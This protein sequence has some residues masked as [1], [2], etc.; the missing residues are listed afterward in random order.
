[1]QVI[2]YNS[3]NGDN[4]YIQLKY[5]WLNRKHSILVRKLGKYINLLLSG[6]E[7]KINTYKWIPKW[8]TLYKEKEPCHNYT[9]TQFFLESDKLTPHFWIEPCGKHRNL[10]MSLGWLYSK[11]KRKQ[12]HFHLEHHLCTSQHIFFL[13]QV[14]LV[15]SCSCFSFQGI[16]DEWLSQLGLGTFF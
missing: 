3:E 1:M 14:S 5:P 4:T 16:I 8:I 7:K 11:Y 2:Y 6:V 12:Y 15:F 10:E 13:Y 9:L